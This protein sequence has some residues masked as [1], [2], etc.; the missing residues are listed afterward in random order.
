MKYAKKAGK[1]SF[2]VG[3]GLFAWPIMLG[4]WLSRHAHRKIEHP[5]LRYLAIAAIMLPAISGGKAWASNIT[6]T[7]NTTSTTQQPVTKTTVKKTVTETKPVPFDDQKVN[8]PT[9]TA[10]QEAVKQTGKDGVKTV[11]FEVTLTNGQETARTQINEQLNT[12]PTPKITLVGSKT[13][14]TTLAPNSNSNSISPKPNPSSA[15]TKPPG[16]C[17]PNYT[18]CVPIASDVDCLGGSGNGP[19]YV[20][21]PVKVIGRDIYKL[22]SDHD[23]WGCEN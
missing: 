13:T 12:P 3:L 9:L 19:A 1:I 2:L 21:G 14:T 5:V 17:D 7:A 15:T 16:N 23:G 20:R 10:G 6:N 11:T 18:P 22:D 8:D 4:F